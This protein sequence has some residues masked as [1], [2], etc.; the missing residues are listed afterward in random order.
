MRT[1]PASTSA[2]APGP[3]PVK[4]RKP[5]GREPEDAPDGAVAKEAN[6]VGVGP[7]PGGEDPGFV[8]A[9]ISSEVVVV[10]D[11]GSVVEVAIVVDDGGTVVD[12]PPEVVV[13]VVVV[14]PQPS[15]RW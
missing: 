13:V 15:N 14:E 11:G 10:V 4:A 3:S 5:P 1:T 6:V 2:S 12:P 7:R 8:V 9:G